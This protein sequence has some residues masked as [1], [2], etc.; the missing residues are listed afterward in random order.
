VNFLVVESGREEQCLG[1]V[2]R[3][4]QPTLEVQKNEMLKAISDGKAELLKLEDSI[5]QRLNDPNVNL[6]EDEE[7]VV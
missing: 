2:V 3:A 1:I 7:L 5:L 6:L 4:E